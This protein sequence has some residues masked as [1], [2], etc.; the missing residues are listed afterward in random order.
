MKPELGGGAEQLVGG[1]F[2]SGNGEAEAPAPALLSWLATDVLLLVADLRAAAEPEVD[3]TVDGEP[4]EVETRWL[5][6]SAEEGEDA[7]TTALTLW[8]SRPVGGRT[9]ELRLRGGEEEIGFGPA[10]APA[11]AVD[12]RTTIREKLAGLEAETREQLLGF[13][14]ATPGEHA[15]SLDPVG[16]AKSLFVLREALRDPYPRTELRADDVQGLHVGAVARVDDRTFFV[17]GW[18]RDDQAPIVRLDAVSPEGSRTPILERLFR[19]PR[20]DLEELFRGAPRP[21]AKPGFVC[22]FEVESPSRLAEG[23]VFELENSAGVAIEA[24]APAATVDPLAVRD[25]ILGEL[26]RERRVDTPLMDQLAPAVVRLQGELSGR[27]EVDEVE[28]FGTP[29]AEPDVSVIVPLYRRVDLIEHQLAQFAND[30]AMFGAE[31]IYVLD[32][33][34]LAPELLPRVAELHE[35]YRIPFR[36]AILSRNGGFAVASNL[37]ASLA[38][39]RLVLLLNSDVLPDRPGWLPRLVEAH[40]GLPQAGVVAPKLLYDDG[41]IQHAGLEFRRNPASGG[42]QLAHAFKGLH[43]GFPKAEER[44][45]V[46]ALSGAC[47]LLE[48][49]LYEDL[50]GFS[51][52]YVKG[53]YEDAELCMELAE[54][55]LEAWYVPEV[56]LFHLE[57]RS[58]VPSATDMSNRFNAWLFDQ[59]WGERAERTATAEEA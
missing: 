18:A 33:P 43:R 55:D 38:S 32:S 37:G 56:E 58:Y 27:V 24:S 12:L 14:A 6:P 36:L 15:G 2:A 26:V 59:R 22:F 1:P 44:R 10:L 8:V 19:V 17:R 35:L 57:G 29:P 25:T 41:S 20:P 31:L 51:V 30:P 34:E 46:P 52:D 3:L 28:D 7:A 13:L 54:R 9:V 40:D 21:V 16:L 4:V 23:W 11:V 47:L 53:G 50:G 5:P 39:G 42:W 45:A 49:E 48:R